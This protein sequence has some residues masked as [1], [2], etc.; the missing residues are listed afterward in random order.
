MA[1]HINSLPRKWSGGGIVLTA[2]LLLMAP[3]CATQPFV[4]GYYF[5]PQP[6]TVEVYH[7]GAGQ[8]TP[9]TVLASVLGVRRADTKHHIPYSM[10]VRLRL[11]NNGD[12]TIQFDPH[13]MELVTG[14]LRAFRPPL[15]N[16]AQP[17]DLAPG[18]RRD[19]TAYFPFP[20]GTTASQTNLDN[21]RLRW[22]VRIDNYSVQQTAMFERTAPDYSYDAVDQ[23]FY[24]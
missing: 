5:Y 4:S 2:L 7:R 3:G 12:A 17:V 21:L 1:R 9:L 10:A 18:Q 15:T 14:T 23:N 16:P 19:V 24:Y 13:S 22:E 6:A 20:A 11:E 8:Q